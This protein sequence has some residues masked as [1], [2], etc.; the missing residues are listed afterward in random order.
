ANLRVEE[1]SLT[2][3]SVPVDK[4]AG[5]V[6]AE[7]VDL[8][9]RLNMVYAGTS[10]ARGRARAI[11]VGTGEQTELGGIARMLGEI[12]E[13]AT[14][15]QRRLEGLGRWLALVTLGICAVVFLAGALRGIPLT[16]MLLTSVSLAVAAIPEGLPAVVTIVL[17]LGMQNMVQRHAIIRRL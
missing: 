10:V 9:D 15:L 11:V 1:A 16:D 7:D 8:G 3:E 12:E 17:A 2:G 6:L 14:P 4:S 5:V 13:E